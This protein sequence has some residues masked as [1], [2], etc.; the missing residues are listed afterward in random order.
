MAAIG[1]FVTELK[2][3][4]LVLSGDLNLTRCGISL[5]FS[6]TQP[7][8]AR[9]QVRKSTISVVAKVWPGGGVRLGDPCS[10][11]Y[12]MPAFSQY[13]EYVRF[14]RQFI[15]CDQSPCHL[16][17]MLLIAITVYFP[18]QV[19]EERQLHSPPRTEIPISVP[20]NPSR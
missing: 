16:P 11:E 15:K 3:R 2:L 9:R 6:S 18:D 8:P 14:R 10:L 17:S 19:A 5:N 13:L 7:R 4:T 12:L 20:S 1:S